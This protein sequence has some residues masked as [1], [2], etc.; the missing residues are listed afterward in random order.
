MN[1]FGAIGPWQIIILLGVLLIGIVPAIIALIDILRSEFKSNNKLI[2]VLVV[3]F[4]SFFGAI[5]YFLIGK[6]QKT[7]IT[8][9]EKP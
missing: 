5:L 4:C 3:L 6:D 7:Q 1:Y 2:W 8:K 9:I